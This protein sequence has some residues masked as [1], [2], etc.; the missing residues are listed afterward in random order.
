VPRIGHYWPFVPES[1]HI[2]V[3]IPAYPPENS[4]LESVHDD[5]FI[6]Q[7]SSLRMQTVLAEPLDRTQ[8]VGGSN[9]PSSID[10]E[11][12]QTGQ[13]GSGEPFERLRLAERRLPSPPL[14]DA[15]RL[16]MPGPPSEV[17]SC[18]EW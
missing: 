2:R 15:F 5:L 6:L 9:P 11:G 18:C 17:E 1:P 12:P 10:E 8:E 7:I 4:G 16:V 14:L 3:Y 13:I